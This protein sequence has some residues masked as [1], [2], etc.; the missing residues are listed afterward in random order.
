MKSAFS[1]A[2]LLSMSL[3]AS[4]AMPASAASN[5]GVPVAKQGYLFAGGKYSAVNG[6]QVLDRK[7][8]RLN[9]SHT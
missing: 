2:L 4:F 3:A 6:K 5:D 9:S 1:A 8:T 7:S